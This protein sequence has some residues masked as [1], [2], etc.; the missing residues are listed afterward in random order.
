M[1]R[2]KKLTID[3]MDIGLIRRLVKLPYFQFLLLAP[4]ALFFSLAAISIIFGVKHPGFNFGMVFTWV[5]WW[6]MLLILFVIFGRGWCAMCPFGAFGEWLQR[7]S[8]WWKRKWSLGFNFKYPRRLQNLWLA[9]GVF[10]IFIFLDNGYGLSNSPTLTFGLIAVIILGALWVSL[11]FERRTFCIYHCPLTVLIGMSSMFAPFEIRRKDADVCRQCKEKA[12]FRGSEQAYGCPT[13]EFQGGG[14]D[15]NRNCLLCTECIRAC[16]H[17]NIGMRIRGWGHDLWARRKG[18]LDESVA[19]V[20]IAGLV[21]MVSLFLVL[22]LPMT[23]S[24]VE[25]IF[26]GA[27][28]GD[29]PRVASIGVLFMGGL[30]I[31]LLLMYGFSHLSRLFS[32]V[33][34]TGTKTFFIHF[35]Y[36]VIPLGVMKFISDILDHVFRTWGAIFDVV[37]ALFLDFP[38]NRVIAEEVTVKQLMTADQTYLMQLVLT[39][40]GFGFSLYVA[41]KLAGRMF[42]DRDIAFRA[43]LPIGAFIFIMGMAALWALSAAL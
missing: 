14:M 29:L 13:F 5:V 6:G 12:C 11:F 34:D 33:K 15:T 2:I 42:P 22:F 3:L 30:V 32:G 10:V 18:K 38:L 39:G 1:K 24:F 28:Q 31:A 9:I 16:P 37:R 40:I 36:A 35:G 26:P 27:A 43:F 7:L 8:L 41:Y 4:A 21:T 23:K 17:D 20:I 19:A 25:T